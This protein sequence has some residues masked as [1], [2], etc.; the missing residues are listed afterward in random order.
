M[1]KTKHTLLTALTFTA[2]LQTATVANVNA[3][4]EDEIGAIGVQVPFNA[5]AQEIQDVYGPA[6][7]Y[8]DPPVTTTGPWETTISTAVEATNTTT[9]CLYGPT[10]A[11]TPTS[12]TTRVTET[13]YGPPWVFPGYTGT[14][15]D[16]IVTTTTTEPSEIYGPPIAFYEPGDLNGD[17]SVDVFDVIK[18]RKMLLQNMKGD[19]SWEENFADINEDNEFGVA[20]LVAMQNYLLGRTHDF[21]TK[22]STTTTTTSTSETEPATTTTIDWSIVVPLY[23][24]PEVLSTYTYPYYTYPPET[25]MTTVTP[26]ITMQLMYGPP[27]TRPWDDLTRTTFIEETTTKT[28]TKKPRKTTTKTSSIQTTTTTSLPEFD[29]IDTTVQLMYGPPEY[30]ETHNK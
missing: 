19:P 20:D 7:N 8:N 25:T 30:F 4:T 28:T 1:K 11:Y 26:D 10:S 24:P 2:A 14:M 21:K 12:T 6:P 18:L 17:G 3:V 13:L 23:G 5:A 29:P 16:D 15:P 27:A 22:L 9:V